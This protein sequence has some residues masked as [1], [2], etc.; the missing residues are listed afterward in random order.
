MSSTCSFSAGFV[1]D[2]P[3]GTIIEFIEIVAGIYG[4]PTKY[5]RIY[6]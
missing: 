2:A 4:V 6:K 1:G 5:T 3:A